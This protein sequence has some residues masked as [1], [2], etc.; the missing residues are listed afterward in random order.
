MKRPNPP[1]ALKGLPFQELATLVA[2]GR[3]VDV[4]STAKALKL[5]PL[6]IQA[7]MDSP[8]FLEAVERLRKIRQAM[9]E[10]DSDG[11]AEDGEAE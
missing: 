5:S 10:V 3:A 6:A 2:I 11:E 8:A 9:R 4:D 1:N 7:T